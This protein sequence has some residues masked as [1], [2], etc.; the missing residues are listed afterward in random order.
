MS[1]KATPYNEGF[2]T[3]NVASSMPSARHVLG[4]LY[5]L[6]QPKSVVDIGCGSGAWL[7]G[8]E[9]FGSETLRGYDGPWAN[10]NEFTSQKIDFVPIDLEHADLVH[11]QSY[12][13]AIS[14]EVAEHLSEKRSGFIVDALCT[15]SQIVLFSAAIPQQGGT[16]HIHERPQTYWIAKFAERGYEVFDIFRPAIWDNDEVRWWFRQNLLLFVAKDCAILDRDKLRSMQ[17]P[18]WDVVHPANYQRKIRIGRDQ[19]SKQ[20]KRTDDL[21]RKLKDV[22]AERNDAIVALALAK[23]GHQPPRPRTIAEVP[24]SLRPA[25]R[26]VWGVLPQSVKAKIKQK[27]G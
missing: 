10:P 14:V 4:I 8:C 18:L 26:R 16:H 23:R 9:S 17:P 7:A 3:K 13:L 22:T 1:S 27:R 11:T 25:A 5:G 21:E 19:L 24:G 2:F 6:Y 20:A 15:A 12:D